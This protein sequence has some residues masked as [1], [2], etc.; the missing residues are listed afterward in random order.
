ML[1]G[2]IG[3]LTVELTSQMGYLTVNPIFNIYNSQSPKVIVPMYYNNTNRYSS[4]G[5]WGLR[6]SEYG[7]RRLGGLADSWSVG[8][9]VSADSSMGYIITIPFLAIRPHTG[10]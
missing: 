7:T 5:S 4:I 9:R 2:Q 6:E 1:T 10:V 8:V 3:Y